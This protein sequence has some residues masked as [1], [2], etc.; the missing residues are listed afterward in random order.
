MALIIQLHQSQDR[1]YKSTTPWTQPKF[2]VS[3]LFCSVS[4]LMPNLPIYVIPSLLFVSCCYTFC[5]K[6]FILNLKKKELIL[7]KNELFH[8][9][10]FWEKYIVY[11]LLV[12]LFLQC[13]WEEKERSHLVEESLS[14]RNYCHGY[15]M[16]IGFGAAY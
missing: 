15:L 8:V 5:Y 13:R 2:T 10:H 4:P 11:S 16:D 6:I 1:D 12:L 7:T 3:N 9:L 14:F